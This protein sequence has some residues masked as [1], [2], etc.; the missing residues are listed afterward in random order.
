MVYSTKNQTTGLGMGKAEGEDRRR[1]PERY[2]SDGNAM[3]HGRMHD[4]MRHEL[5]GD[6]ARQLAWCIEDLLS[7]RQPTL[8]APLGEV[9]VSLPPIE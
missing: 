7:G 8:D 4:L 9:Q 3:K 6:E 5:T 1:W 2:R